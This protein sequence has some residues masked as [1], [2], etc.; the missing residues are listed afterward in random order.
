[1]PGKVNNLVRDKNNE[2]SA[3]FTGAWRFNS[4]EKYREKKN[5]QQQAK[6]SRLILTR[7]KSRMIFRWKLMYEPVV[8]T[9]LFTIVTRLWIAAYF[10]PLSLAFILNV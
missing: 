1:M 2:I 6:M 10:L 8:P 3:L 4:T 5:W 9:I 7:A